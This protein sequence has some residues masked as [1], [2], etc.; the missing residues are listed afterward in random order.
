MKPHFTLHGGCLWAVSPY[1]GAS[2]TA[3]GTTIEQAWLNYQV[4]QRRWQ[5]PAHGGAA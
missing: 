2:Y 5:R 4:D 3:L 1:R